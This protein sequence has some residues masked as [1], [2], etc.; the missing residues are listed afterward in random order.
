MNFKTGDAIINGTGVGMPR[1]ILAGADDAPRVKIGKE[2]NQA[3]ATVV[4][5]NLE[6]MYAR[7][8]SRYIA[9]AK[10]YINQDVWP[11]LFS[12]QKAVGTGGVPVFLPGGSVAGAPFGTIFGAPIVPL[13][14]SKTLGTEGDIIFANLK[15]YGTQTRGTVES[16]MSIH[17]KFDFGQTAFRFLT[18]VDGQ[19][20]ISSSITPAN[21]TAKQSPFITLAT[22]S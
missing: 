21:G 12:M 7:M 18:E 1:G 14:Y 5:T 20:W 2:T 17:L 15:A 4:V 19:P 8:P 16:A 13:E 9:G 10:W 11:A 22:R 6:K 3:A